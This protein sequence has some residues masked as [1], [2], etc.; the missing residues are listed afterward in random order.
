MKV[1]FSKQQEYIPT[2]RENR[3]LPEEEQIK[4]VLKPL[5]MGDLVVLID[6]LQKAGAGNVDPE[7][8]TSDGSNK[9]QNIKQLVEDAGELVPKYCEV[10]NLL[11]EDDTPI[12]TK[13]IV[14]FPFYLELVAEL[15]TEL[16]SISMPNEREVKNSKMQPGSQ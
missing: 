16:A 2:W 6:G 5:Q 4:V 9:L 15:L 10:Y 14:Q 7:S 1:N 11:G 13:E 12:Q 8:L 3:N